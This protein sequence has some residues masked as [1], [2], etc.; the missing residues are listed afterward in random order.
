[1][2]IHGLMK[3]LADEA[4]QSYKEGEIKNYFGRVVAIDASMSI[5]QFLIAVRNDGQNLSNEVCGSRLTNRTYLNPRL[6]V[7][8]RD[9][10]PL[11]RHVLPHDPHDR[12]RDQARVRV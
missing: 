6:H 1:M 5:Y 9:H 4:P 12:E 8:R 3:V 2:G 11:D 7:G 10:E